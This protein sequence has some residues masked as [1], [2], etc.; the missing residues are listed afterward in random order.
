MIGRVVKLRAKHVPWHKSGFRLIDAAV[1]IWAFVRVEGDGVYRVWL[2]S[3]PGRP[4]IRA[5]QQM[6]EAIAAKRYLLGTQL[7]FQE[8]LA[9]DNI[10]CYMQTETV[11]DN[12]K[13][14]WEY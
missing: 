4:C 2:C 9:P 1:H 14:S 8:G 12:V 3:I 7:A 10:S 13:R 11:R 6:R 5:K